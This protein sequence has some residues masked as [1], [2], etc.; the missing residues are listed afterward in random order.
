[1]SLADP[2]VLF[3]LATITNPSP[4]YRDGPYRRLLAYARPYVWRWVGVGIL[5]LASSGVALLQPWPL[6]ILFDQVL[7]DKPA[8]GWMTHLSGK[9]ELL[10]CIAAASFTLYVI[11]SLL[12]GAVSYSWI[13]VGQRMVYDVARDLFSVTQRQSL[14]FH[15]KHPVGDSMSRIMTDSWCVYNVV[16]S[17]V[18]TPG[19]AIVTLVGMIVIMSRMNGRLTL[20]AI[21]VAP[22]VSLGSMMLA[23]RLRRIAKARREIESSMQAHVQQVLSG[24][25]VVKAFGQEEREHERFTDFAS[26]AIRAFR[27]GVFVTNLSNLYTGLV[28]AVG[29]GFVLLIGARQ[30]LRDELTLGELLLFIS[31][32]NMMQSQVSTLARTYVALQSRRAEID[33]VNEILSA[34]NEIVDAPSA[35]SVS[36][37][38]GDISIENV[39]FGYEPDRPVLRDVSLSLRA[40]ETI[41]LVGSTGAGKTTLASMVPRFFDPWSG[42]V[43][44]DGRDVREVRVRGLREQVSLVLQEPFL[45]PI[46][47]AQNIAFGKPDAPRDAIKRAAEAA[48]AAEFIEQ[49]PDGYNTTIGERGATLSGGQKQRLSIA[50]ALL[51]DSPI[52][53]L[54]EPTAAL[55]TV[56]EQAILEAMRRLM[57]NRTTL[58]IAHRLSTIRDADQIAVLEAGRIVELGKHEQLLAMNGIYSRFCAA[59][60]IGERQA[61]G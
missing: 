36:S 21:V 44:I 3:R 55:D 33:R 42:C 22:I 32:L 48:N 35:A 5:L 40:G 17:L 60:E 47:I 12:D 51:K 50:R 2:L 29:N 6:Q 28:L 27:R 4:K 8:P 57:K 38:R 56:T 14:R 41:A 20:A 43:R 26:A 49:L 24:I 9:G 25:Q 10:A 59:Q 23:K 52:L 58:I 11:S 34:P 61:N 54:D 45:F 1:M 7:D 13:R 53:I 39:T 31:Y 30:V 19:Q 16:E 37:T 18:M 15:H 46:S